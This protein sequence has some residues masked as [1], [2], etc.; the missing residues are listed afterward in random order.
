MLPTAMKYEKLQRIMLGAE[1]R[2]EEAH[3]HLFIFDA[4][5]LYIITDTISGFLFAHM[6]FVGVQNLTGH[7]INIICYV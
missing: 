6:L 5:L 7:Q 4:C 3:V 2:K 1:F